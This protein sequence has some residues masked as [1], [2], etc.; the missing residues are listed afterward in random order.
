MRLDQQKILIKNE[1]SEL[2]TG[3]EDYIDK[4]H[5]EQRAFD[6]MSS[7]VFFNIK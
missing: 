1:Q 7:K 5:S 2:T 4:I 6:D 3:Y